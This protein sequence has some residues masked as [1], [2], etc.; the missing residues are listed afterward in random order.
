MAN[1]PQAHVVGGVESGLG[2]QVAVREAPEGAVDHL[3]MLAPQG[4]AGHGSVHVTRWSG[5]GTLH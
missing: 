3:Q 1:V 4:L 5:A 2:T